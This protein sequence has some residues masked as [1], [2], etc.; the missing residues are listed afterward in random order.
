MK[1]IAKQ[2]AAGTFIALLL[3]GGNVKATETK[4]SSRA[5]DETT[6][7]LEEWMTDEIV[8]NTNSLNIT[9]FAVEAETSLE[10]ENWM[11]SENSWDVYNTFV[12]EVESE[13]GL[14]VW[15]TNDETWNTV[16]NDIESELTVE[17]W[18]VNSDIWE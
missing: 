7:Q 17:S 5:M 11:T 3:M 9:E 16:N 10:L 13:M 18:M 14:E 2:L 12:E 8:W 15:M 6:L 1:T 4:T